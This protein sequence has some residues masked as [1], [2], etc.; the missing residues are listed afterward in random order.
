VKEGR[1]REKVSAFVAHVVQWFGPAFCLRRGIAAAIPRQGFK[2]YWFDPAFSPSALD[3]PSE[4]CKVRNT[5]T[6]LP[7]LGSGAKPEDRR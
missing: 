2:V 4:T 5:V 7:K 6:M 3:P 1:L